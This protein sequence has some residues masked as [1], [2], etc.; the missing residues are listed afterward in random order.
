[1]KQKMASANSDAIIFK[2]G[3]CRLHGQKKVQS[4]EKRDSCTLFH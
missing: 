3:H 4:F 1:M 2:R